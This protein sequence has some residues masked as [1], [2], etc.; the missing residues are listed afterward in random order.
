MGIILA[1]KQGTI[2]S[3]KDLTADQVYDNP[4]INRNDLRKM[5]LDI[6]QTALLFGTVN[7]PEWK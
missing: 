1:D 7:V 4:E 6:W 5:L 2:L 3:V